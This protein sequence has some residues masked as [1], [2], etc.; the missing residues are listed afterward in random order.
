VRALVE[1]LVP[2]ASVLD[3]TVLGPGRGS[4][5]GATEKAIGYGQPV[6]ITARL[7]GGATRRF[8][9]HTAVAGDFGHERR[10]DRAAEMLLAFDTFPRI[11]S[12][13]EAVDVGAI[14]DGG[15]VSLRRAGEFYLLTS[16]A[17]GHLYAEEL[18][19]IADARR[20]SPEDVARCE[21]LA[22]YLVA[23]HRE[24]RDCPSAYVRAIRDLVGHGEGIFGLIDGYPSDVPAAPPARLEAIERRCVAWRWRLRGREA[25]L[26]RTHGDFHPFNVV[27]DDRGEL[28]L[29]DASRGS[30]GDPADDV[31]CMA[32]NYAFFAV[33]SPGAWEGA[34]RG[35]WRRFWGLYLAESG[36]A[37]LLEAAPPY[38]AWRALVLANPRWYP[39]LAA[40]ARDRLLGLVEGTLDRGRL[41][42][43]DAEALF[44]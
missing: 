7:P 6:E 31:T 33:G 16:Y 21:R 11:P 25:R 26:A 30:E 20:A 24:R 27:F 43:D 40:D 29:L 39:A 12:H 14:V 32:I 28:S 15:L 8:V 42:P 4:A 5:G 37:G 41:D 34:L 1:A 19:R 35:L 23:L 22:R 38:F 18:R 36:D 2:G 13:V 17:D 10:A 44:R 9:L 3:V